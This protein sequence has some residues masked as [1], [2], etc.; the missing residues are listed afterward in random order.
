MN[1]FSRCVRV[2]AWGFILFLGEPARS[3]AP[4][5]GPPPPKGERDAGPPGPP[6]P[7]AG[8]ERADD[9]GPAR[10]PRVAIQAIDL[11]RRRAGRAMV[12]VADH[13]DRRPVGHLGRFSAGWT[14]TV[15]WSAR[16]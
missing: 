13:R 7:R 6:P 10:T 2:A 3:A 15:R 11:R 1:Y 16:H 4:P 12:M 5:D 14:A 8:R 9:G